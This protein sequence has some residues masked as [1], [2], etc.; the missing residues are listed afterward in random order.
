MK[1]SIWR[2]SSHLTFE[3]GDIFVRRKNGRVKVMT[4]STDRCRILEDCY[5][6][7]TSGHF[8]VTKSKKKV[9]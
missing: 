9:S 4:N 8:G 7:P 2:R 3:I 6:A 1:R 5:S